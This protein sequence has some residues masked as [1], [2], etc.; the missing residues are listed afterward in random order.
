MTDYQYDWLTAEDREILGIDFFTGERLLTLDEERA[1]ERIRNR[2]WK[3]DKPAFLCLAGNGWVYTRNGP[4]PCPVP[5]IN[6]QSIIAITCNIHD[7]T[8]MYGY[9]VPYYCAGDGNR[10]CE[11]TLAV[12]LAEQGLKVDTMKATHHGSFDSF[13]HA[14]FEAFQPR[15]YVV[16]AGLE[17]GHPCE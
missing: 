4:M 14:L 1:F 3:H 7:P 8:K 6:A 11:D 5:D 10:E 15:N 13:S 17:H 9:G 16:S 12:Y 2:Q